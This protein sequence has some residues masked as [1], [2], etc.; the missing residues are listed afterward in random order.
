MQQRDNLWLQ[1]SCQRYLLSAGVGMRVRHIR[2]AIMT[3][4]PHI[5]DLLSHSL[6]HAM[7]QK[8]MMQV[9]DLVARYQVHLLL[10][11]SEQYRKASLSS[12][13]GVGNMQHSQ[14]NQHFRVN[15]RRE[16]RLSWVIRS[17]LCSAMIGYSLHD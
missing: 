17:C 8:I 12:K 2:G 6:G 10:H 13:Q 1:F 7:R 5:L 16:T 11:R 9:L 14:G 3:R 4:C 15:H